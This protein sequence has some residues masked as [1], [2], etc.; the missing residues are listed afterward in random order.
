[1][2]WTVSGIFCRNL[3]QAPS[4]IVNFWIK[5]VDVLFPKPNHS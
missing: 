4:K 5:F 1:M 3:V 2:F